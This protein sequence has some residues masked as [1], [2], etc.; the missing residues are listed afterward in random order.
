M[1]ATP[2]AGRRAP[3]AARPSA[4]ASSS[5][6]CGSSAQAAPASSKS[7]RKMRWS[8]AIAPVW[9]S[10]AAAPGA[11]GAR[12]EHGDADARVR[13]ALQRRA[14]ARAVAVGLQVQRDRAHAVALGDR[15]EEVRGVE[16]RLVAARDDRV[17][18][19][20]APR[21]ERVDGDVAALRDQRDRARL[22]RH[23]HVAPQRDAIRAARRS[24]CRSARTPA[25]RAA[26]AQRACSSP[27]RLREPAANTTAPPQPSA[28]ARSTTS[29]ARSGIATTTASG[30]S[31]RSSSDGYASTPCTTAAAG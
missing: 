16:H 12:L 23:E 30:A 6:S 5:R 14:P 20:P 1:T 7:A 31:G 28:A 22:A 2:A 8:P 17:Q 29:G 19:Q 18:P 4:F 26:A 21:G 15:G 11:R 3:G 24:R 10:A 27:S 13:A 9:A 25:A